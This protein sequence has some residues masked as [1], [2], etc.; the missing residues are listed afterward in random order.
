MTSSDVKGKS[1]IGSIT[2]AIKALM[3]L[4]IDL[5]NVG[6]EGTAILSTTVK[7]AR[8]DHARQTAVN[9]SQAK[10]GFAKQAAMTASQADAVIDAWLGSNPKS[11]PGYESNL[12][13]IN[14]AI[15]EAEAEV[16]R[17]RQQ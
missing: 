14:E 5:I 12:A 10:V 8:L 17:S 1:F 16:L 2:S 6:S 3:M 7:Q 13:R 11:K 9:A 4:L 15:A